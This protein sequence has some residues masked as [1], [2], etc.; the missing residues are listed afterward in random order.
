MKTLKTILLLLTFIFP[1]SVHSQNICRAVLQAP[2]APK[3]VTQI[4]PDKFVEELRPDRPDVSKRSP[5]S[6]LSPSEASGAQLIGTPKS[7]N[8]LWDTLVHSVDCKSLPGRPGFISFA[9]D[10]ATATI[11]KEVLKA[12]VDSLDCPVDSTIGTRTSCQKLVTEIKPEDTVVKP[13]SLRGGWS[14]LES[15]NVEDRVVPVPKD[16]TPVEA[17]IR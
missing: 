1:L 9:K 8:P 14:G 5:L 6:W 15:L 10:F 7:G 4:G 12:E 2:I 11:A 13:A 3:R 16:T 17:V